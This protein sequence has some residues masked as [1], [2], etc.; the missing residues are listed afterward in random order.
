M[1]APEAPAYLAKVT[2]TSL[3]GHPIQG[4]A[5][6]IAPDLLLTCRHVIWYPRESGPATKVE[7]H[8]ANRTKPVRA[9]VEHPDESRDLALLRLPEPV[10]AIVLPPWSTPPDLAAH[11]HLYASGFPKGKFRKNRH[12]VHAIQQDRVTLTGSVDPGASGGVV[13]CWDHPLT[14]CVA[15]I[16]AATPTTNTEALRMAEIEEYLA[17][18]RIKLPKPAPPPPPPPP[19]HPAKYLAWLRKETSEIDLGALNIG[20]SEAATV[21]IEKLWVPARTRLPEPEPRG[22]SKSAR[23]PREPKD[24]TLVDAI[25][26]YRALVIEGEAGSG[27]STFLRRV[28]YA[29]V[30][31][32]GKDAAKEKLPIAF[33]GAFPLFLRVT[34]LEDYLAAKHPKDAPPKN[35]RLEWIAN[36]LGALHRARGVDARFFAA[37]L[38]DPNS[39]LLL[40]GLDEAAGPWRPVLANLF[41]DARETFPCRMVLTMRPEVEHSRRLL[42]LRDRAPILDMSDEEVNLFLTQWSRHV[43]AH[44]VESARAHSESLRRNLD[45]RPAIRRMARNPLM[46]TILASL[47]RRSHRLPEQRAALYEKIVQWLADVRYPDENAR[48][49]LLRDL[50]FLALEMIKRERDRKYQIDPGAAAELIAGRR[51]DEDNTSARSFLA[52]AQ[53]RSGLITERSGR[54]AFWHRSFQEFLAARRLQGM[55]NLEQ[56]AA[57][58]G[59]MDSRQSPEVLRLLAG[60]LEPADRDQL[61]HLF[62]RLISRENQPGRELESQAYAVGVIG[63]MLADLAPAQYRLPR[64]VQE[65][66]ERLRASVMKIFHRE[67]SASI[68]LPIRVA[69]ADALAQ[70]EDPRLRLPHQEDYWI[71]VP[72]GSFIMGAQN[73]DRKRPDYDPEAWEDEDFGGKRVQVK[74]FQIGRFPVTVHEYQEYLTRENREPS[75]DMKWD[76]QLQYP[77]RPVVNVTR[78]EAREYCRFA[79]GRLPTEQEWE[80]AARGPGDKP[81]RYPWGSETPDTSRA[82]YNE[83]WGK[84]TTAVGLFPVGATPADEERNRIHDMAGNV[85]EWVEGKQRLRGGS[86]HS[87]ARFLRASYRNVVSIVDGRGVLIGFRCA[88]DVST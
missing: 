31:H 76:E 55:R 37:K 22:K 80:F 45:S 61:G 68:A 57:V 87:E 86:F 12:Q 42:S 23:Q 81:R 49:A 25:N 54:L 17:P 29:L 84:G 38:A 35:H 10:P 39:I 30:R 43:P 1:P 27:K 6:F 72:G 19:N 16:Q 73:K 69:A 8:L 51:N 65:E 79:R 11:A 15:L 67:E 4:S 41:D 60:C 53:Q 70:G 46:L 88:R 64:E 47:T 48:N 58:I 7:V 13:E 3:L 28:A 85:W 18:L 9:K 52:D 26:R 75:P 59:L 5:V 78:E 71:T 20:S 36:C 56:E 82:N 44:D 33:P 21:A 50:S 32:L 63:G 14:C 24:A 2:A 74:T 83:S 66:W 34:A 62:Q 77:S 40:D